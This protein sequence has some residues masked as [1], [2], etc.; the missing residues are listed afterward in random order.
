MQLT[1]NVAIFET[2][3]EVI[4]FLKLPLVCHITRTYNANA[5]KYYL[6]APTMHHG[7]CKAKQ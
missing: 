1:E 4:N 7:A 2:S 3:S 6:K 5:F